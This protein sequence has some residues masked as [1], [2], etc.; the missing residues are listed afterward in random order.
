MIFY[1]ISQKKF[2]LYIYLKGLS[3]QKRT[4]KTSSEL[5]EII[6][7]KIK[8]FS[9]PVKEEFIKQFTLIYADDFEKQYLGVIEKIKLN[10]AKTQD[11]AQIYYS[12]ISSFL[13]EKVTNNPTVSIGLR[14][15]SKK[16]IDELISSGKKVIF[17]SSFSELLNVE[18]QRKILHKLFFK[19][20]LNT[21]PHDRIFIINVDNSEPSSELKDIVLTLK[22]KWSNNNKKSTPDTD[23]FVP[24]IYFAGINNLS[25]INL[26]KELQQDD[27]I[28]KDGYDFM[29]S[30][31]NLKSL[32][33]NPVFSR[34]LFFR[35]LNG[36]SEFEIVLKNL[37]K[38]GE[39]YQF[40]RSSSIPII[41]DG[42][43][44][45]IQIKTIEDINHI[46]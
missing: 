14:Q 6:G 33:E 39:I 29:D 8:R 32:Q 34:K 2:I 46:L 22:N 35:F 37:K 45:E 20:P 27:Y 18:S 30:T 1:W 13:L 23:R 7:K 43:Y 9:E 10:Y 26:K 17:K 15:T 25:L 12:I 24:Y 16:E 28:I 36:N 44:K 41:F 42:K 3:P 40:I 19:T 38:T 4:L 31:F 11:E 5:T 21:E